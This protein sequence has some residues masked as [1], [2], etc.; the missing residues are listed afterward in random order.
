MRSRSP[1]APRLPAAAALSSM[2]G[3]APCGGGMGHGEPRWD[4]GC[5]SVRDV[6]AR[7]GWAGGTRREMGAEGKDACRSRGGMEIPPR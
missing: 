3:S 1:R 5:P 6:G 7:E 2:M 4:A